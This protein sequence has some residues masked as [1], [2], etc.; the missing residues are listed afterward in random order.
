MLGN[1]K[2]FYG[3][4]TLVTTIQIDANSKIMTSH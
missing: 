3:D 1:N 2:H 4:D